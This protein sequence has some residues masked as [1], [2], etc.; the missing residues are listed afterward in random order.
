MADCC[1]NVQLEPS[2]NTSCLMDRGAN[3]ERQ[4]RGTLGLGSVGPG[5]GNNFGGPASN[6][7]SM[8]NKRNL[9]DKD[10]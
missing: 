1:N 8:S 10:T 9:R 5:M 3:G 2:L 6:N 7:I 4:T